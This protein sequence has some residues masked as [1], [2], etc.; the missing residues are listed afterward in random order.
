LSEPEYSLPSCPV[1]RMHDM[2]D[3]PQ[4]EALSKVE[5]KTNFGTLDRHGVLLVWEISSNVQIQHTVQR[6]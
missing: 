3:M 4:L 6:A 1:D 5:T 2:H